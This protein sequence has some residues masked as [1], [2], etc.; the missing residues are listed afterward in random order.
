MLMVQMVRVMRLV[1]WRKGHGNAAHGTKVHDTMAARAMVT[2]GVSF[3]RERM[4]D[5]PRNT[6]RHCQHRGLSC[7]RMCMQASR[8][9][10]KARHMVQVM[11][12]G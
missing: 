1:P 8:Y 12:P 5:S 9:R 10:A 6:G 7:D 11:H 3:F 2:N 4:Q